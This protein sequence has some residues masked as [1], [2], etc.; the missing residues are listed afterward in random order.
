MTSETELLGQEPFP[1]TPYL[2]QSPSRL[3]WNGILTSWW[4]YDTMR[5]FLE[6]RVGRQRTD[7]KINTKETHFK[8]SDCMLCGLIQENIVCQFIVLSVV[9]LRA[10]YGK[11]VQF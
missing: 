11:T 5:H 3:T 6:H 8:S 10:E 7:I 1:V 9:A 4:L 2:T